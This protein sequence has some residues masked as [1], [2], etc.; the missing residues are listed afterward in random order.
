MREITFEFLLSKRFDK[1]SKKIQDIEEKNK[2]Y[3]RKEELLTKLNIFINI[4]FSVTLCVLFLDLG[5][6]E[7]LIGIFFWISS[8]SIL[9][10]PFFNI[11]KKNSNI[12]T[13]IKKYQPIICYSRFYLLK[14]KIENSDFETLLINQDLI[15]AN[16]HIFN[17]EA[18][19]EI[20]EL[21]NK[22]IVIKQNS[23]EKIKQKMKK[24]EEE[25]KQIKQHN[26][27]KHI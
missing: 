23:I 25:S 24:V 26:F 1:Y 18:Q 13:K 3:V 15:F 7:I 12:N 19:E 2:K 10:L 9:L 8:F 4:A 22:K 27:I 16:I 14:K 6:W 5:L 11:I 21:F 20:L 17:V